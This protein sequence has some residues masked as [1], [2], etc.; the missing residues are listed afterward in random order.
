MQNQ[1]S[2]NQNNNQ[3]DTLNQINNILHEAGKAFG[4][5]DLKKA[6][7]L[8]EQ[9]LP[10][11][12][13]IDNKTAKASALSRLGIIEQKGG[14]LNHALEYHSSAL[15]IFQDIK[16]HKGETKEAFQIGKIFYYREDYDTALQYFD[17]AIKTS[18]THSIDFDQDA[19]SKYIGLVLY[20]QGHYEVA[21]QY[22]K[23]AL[24]LTPPENAGQQSEICFHLA[25]IHSE[26]GEFNKAIKLLEEALQIDMQLQDINGQGERTCE[27]GLVHYNTGDTITAKKY[28]HQALD[29]F[30]SLDLKDKMIF[31]LENLAALAQTEGNSDEADELFQKVHSIRHGD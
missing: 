21:L 11:C 9:A 17:H 12:D 22:L 7:K 25:K 1:N 24:I 29:I 19:F 5:A 13:E 28:L 3:E 20:R 18:E 30:K 15:E 26:Y 16:L 6:T 14:N 27:L 2:N 23:Q 4:K 8:Y 31:V 10:M